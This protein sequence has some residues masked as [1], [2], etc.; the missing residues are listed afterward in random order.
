MLFGGCWFCCERTD[1]KVYGKNA[2]QGGVKEKS[3][4]AKI[5]GE[6]LE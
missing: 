3:R 6:R 5:E 4:E 2:L 1:E